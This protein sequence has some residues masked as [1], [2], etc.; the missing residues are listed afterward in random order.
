MD[1]CLFVVVFLV[2]LLVLAYLFSKIPIIIENSKN[3]RN[4]RIRRRINRNIIIGTTNSA[5]DSRIRARTFV[6]PLDDDEY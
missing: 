6:P 3:N 5:H 1:S 4:Y 2:I